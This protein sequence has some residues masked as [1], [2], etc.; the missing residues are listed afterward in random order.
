MLS[1]AVWNAGSLLIP[2]LYIVAVSVAVARFLGPSDMGR[3]SFIAFILIAANLVL[4]AGMRD[5]LLRSIGEVVG[6]GEPAVARG[7]VQW[8][9]RTQAVA[10]L[11]GGGLFLVIALAGAEP[12]LAWA[13]AGVACALTILQ[14]VANAAL[15]GLQR[16]REVSIVGVVS[17]ALAVPLT[18]GVLALGGGISGVFAVQAVEAGVGL[19]AVGLLARRSLR[20]L[21]DRA[22]RSQPQ[23]RTARRFAAVTTVGAVATF[24]VWQ[25]SEFFFLAGYSTTAEI[26]I[27]SIAFAAVTA[28]ALIPDGLAETM[29]P[30]L[31]TLHGAGA[32]ERLSAG[33]GR[34]LRL[35]V[36]LSL[37]LLTISFALGPLTIELVYGDEYARSGQVLRIL[38][39]A[40]PVVAALGMANAL[41]V[42]LG[43]PWM[44]AITSLLAGL[45]TIALNFVLVPS[46]GAVG[47]AIANAGG[48][49]CAAVPIVVYAVRLVPPDSL[50]P[51]AL[52]R[53]LL[54]AL[55]AGGAALT[56]SGGLGG[57]AGLL[58]GLALGG[59][60]LL[61]A[62]AALRIL[63]AGD[64]RWLDETAGARARGS[65]GRLCRAWGQA[66]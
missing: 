16:W 64:A 50:A 29:S 46:Y 22:V 48:Q 26:A 32:Q 15:V 4:S 51:G 55:L 31:A 45:V 61:I 20:R 28:L 59:G 53:T 52:A 23:E 21:A 62:G 24:V 40:F 9:G 14:T 1:G 30:A 2:Q 19:L 65:V 18:I 36:L 17:G 7:L 27:Y 60:V 56:A 58:A 43:R 25:R 35:V 42:G 66:A 3:Q 63:P 13:L 47:A 54:C 41:L 8:A 57:L 6:R 11:V 39:A 49:L 38:L 44:P 10:A 34:A 33:F 37:P 12:R 5:G